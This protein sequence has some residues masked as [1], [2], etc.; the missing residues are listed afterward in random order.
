MIEQDRVIKAALAA[1]VI[2]DQR[3]VDAGPVRDVI[4][5]RA[6]EALLREKIRCRRDER[7]SGR[8]GV[9]C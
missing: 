1:E 8:L 4:D 9:P 6:G 5:G 2:A 7:G 3:L